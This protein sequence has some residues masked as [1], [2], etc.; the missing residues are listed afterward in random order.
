MIKDTAESGGDSECGEEPCG[1]DEKHSAE[2]K[3][4]LLLC[5]LRAHVIHKGVNLTK[6][7][8]TKSLQTETWELVL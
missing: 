8:N 2:Q 7:K 5:Q 3:V 6:S 4:K 1:G